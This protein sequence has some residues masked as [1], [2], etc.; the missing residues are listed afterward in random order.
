MKP[1]GIEGLG[2]VPAHWELKRNRYIFIEIN[3]RS[4]TGQETHLT[5]SQIFGLV[6]SF[7]LEEA[8]TNLS[9]YENQVG[10]KVCEVNDLV[11]NK[12]KAYL[13]VFFRA[14]IS[15]LVSPDYTVFRA[16]G[17]VDV[18]YFEYLFKTPAYIAEFTKLSTGIVIG[19][20]RLYT[21]DFY[22]VRA[23][24][25]A[26]QEQERI[27]NYIQQESAKANQAIAQ[28]E[29]EIELIQEYRTTLISDA[30]TGKIDV[31]DTLEKGAALVA[32]G[33]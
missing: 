25:P 18:E 3:E 16:I 8:S 21:P 31:R 1:S 32:G 20:Y 6:E 33:V 11:L 15:G 17:D 29:K 2:E 14:S 23:L 7:N 4:K 10:Y 28:A 13:G 24:L 30:V 12:L 19:F 9:S 22:N 5:M 26:R 27:V